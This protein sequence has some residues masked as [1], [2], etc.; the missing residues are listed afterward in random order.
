[1]SAAPN[2][3]ALIGG[4]R[5]PRLT[6]AA[7]Y[8]HH[9]GW[10]RALRRAA[11]VGLNQVLALSVFECH[12][13]RPEHVPRDRGP[14]RTGGEGRF[15]AAAGIA[16]LAGPLG[17]ELVRD[18]QAAAARGDEV[19]ALFEGG[20]LANIACYAAGA[21]PLM[22]DLE[23]RVDPPSIYTHRNFTL[24]PFRGRRLH[25]AGLLGAASELFARGVPQIIALC[26]WSNYPAM[27][28]LRRTGC[29]R[30][31]LVWR[32]GVGRF[33]HV[34]QSTRTSIRLNVRGPG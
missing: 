33:H 31:G 24:P 27:I 34:G 4:M 20:R 19:Y 7:A 22:H 6:E 3:E 9:V 2:R 12:V 13:L 10:S 14:T 23:V 17:E 15:L 29:Q 8:A 25:A 1:M 21:A 5:F 32:V 26:E 11:Y 16:K 18:F 30:D 28:S